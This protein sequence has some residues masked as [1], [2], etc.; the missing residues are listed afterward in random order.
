MPRPL[1]VLLPVFKDPN[2]NQFKKP[3]DLL[4]APQ[5]P[6]PPSP[7]WPGRPPHLPQ[8]PPSPSQEQWNNRQMSPATASR[9]P[10]SVG[11]PDGSPLWGENR[12]FTN[13][14]ASAVPYSPPSPSPSSTP[15]YS[16]R[17]TS[18]PSPV[19]DDFPA[20]PS[21][22]AKPALPT[23]HTPGRPQVRRVLRVSPQKSSQNTPSPA[24]S[25]LEL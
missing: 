7:Q 22:R 13:N 2:T 14:R 1:Y 24:T 10:P 4:D 25:M 3:K 19:V 12:S 9:S 6:P 20:L 18:T 11:P 15:T 21:S 5:I 17:A 8:I 16:T 23:V